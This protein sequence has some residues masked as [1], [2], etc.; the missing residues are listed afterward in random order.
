MFDFL[1]N[2]FASQAAKTTAPAASL[3]GAENPATGQNPISENINLNDPAVTELLMK[4]MSNFNSDNNNAIPVGA[5]SQPLNFAGNQLKQLYNPP[6][7]VNVMSPAR[8]NIIGSS[9]MRFPR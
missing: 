9:L 2:L 8:R 3:G 7:P 1:K 5:A 6:S 4:L